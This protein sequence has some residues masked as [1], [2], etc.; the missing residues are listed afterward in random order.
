M[1]TQT[2]SALKRRKN[3]TRCT[4]SSGTDLFTAMRCSLY[5][6]GDTTPHF[7]SIFAIFSQTTF[8]TAN[9]E[10]RGEYL[11]WESFEHPRSFSIWDTRRFGEN[12]FYLF[13]GLYI[14]LFW[15]LKILFVMRKVNKLTLLDM[16]CTPSFKFNIEP[17][18]FW[19]SLLYWEFHTKYV[20]RI[21]KG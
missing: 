11:A 12:H 4:L 13:L 20:R 16:Q 10:K 6:A 14:L 21:W 9:I 2:R 17:A 8:H 19:Q 5:C 3:T 18:I 15:I 1:T 7:R